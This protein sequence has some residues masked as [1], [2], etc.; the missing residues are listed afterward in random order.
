MDIYFGFYREKQFQATSSIMQ[1]I[2]IPPNINTKNRYKCPDCSFLISKT[3]SHCP[4]CGTE[5]T[6]DVRRLMEKDLKKRT[7]E[8]VTA[9]IIIM[10]LV[11]LFILWLG[12][13]VTSTK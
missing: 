8:G 13:F 10:L 6:D 4:H 2:Y 11:L 12:T 1:P 3:D 7:R 9:L 5:I